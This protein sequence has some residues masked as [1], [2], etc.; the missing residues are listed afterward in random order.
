MKLDFTGNVTRFTYTSDEQIQELES[1]C[2]DM[3]FEVIH[4]NNQVKPSLK[5]YLKSQTYFIFEKITKGINSHQRWDMDSF[6]I[7]ITSSGAELM[8]NRY[9]DRGSF[10]LSSLYLPLL[11]T[12]CH[13][14]QI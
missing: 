11:L 9:G 1:I 7:S 10:A 14:P 12:E 3:G 6:V 4:E 13:S 8:K 2:E 5:L